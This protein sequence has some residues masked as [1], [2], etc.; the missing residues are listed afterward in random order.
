MYNICIYIYVYIIIEL[1]D[2]SEIK[3]E[4]YI[5]RKKALVKSLNDFCKN[6]AKH[7]KVGHKV[8]DEKL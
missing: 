2:L 5:T 7:I 4:D 6:L 1:E 8:I 3:P